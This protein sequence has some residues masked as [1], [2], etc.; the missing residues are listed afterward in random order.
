MIGFFG[1]ISF[2][3]NIL[4]FIGGFLLSL[5]WI[6]IPWFLFALARGLWLKWRRTLFINKMD[7]ILLEV[8]P[9]KDIKKTAQAMEQFF[10]GLHATMG[11]PDLWERYIDGATQRWHSLEI[12][13]SGEGPHF[14]IRTVS[15]FRDLIE[16]HIY[17]QYPEAEINQVAD[18]VNSV[19]ADIPSEEYDLWGSELIL[20]KEDAYPI[21]TYFEFEKEASS[22]E[23]RIDPIAS[24]MEVLSKI[25]P[26][27]HVWIQTLVRPI[28]DAWQEK[29]EELRDKLVGRK[30]EKKQGEVMKEAVAWKKTSQQAAQHLLTGK[31]SEGDADENDKSE[32]PFIWGKTKGEQETVAAIERNISKL[33][34][35]TIVR[36]LY[37]ARRDS[38]KRPTVNAVDGAYRQFNTQDLNGFKTNS[39][40]KTDQLDYKIELKGPRKNYRSKRILADYRKRDFIQHS[41]YIKYLKPLLFERLPILKW[42]FVRSSPFVLNVEELATI[43]HFPV[44]TVKAPLVP[45]VEARKGEPP[46]GLPKG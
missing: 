13:S 21:R 46:I 14:Y 5:W 16:S 28:G 8:I 35:E 31:P 37:I 17:A 9:P 36:Y 45:K 1:T 22:D 24:L 25:G 11:G 41:K 40:I 43:Y 12:A 27:E 30:V 33:G 20:A 23:Q 29:G 15:R 34:F 3:I 19:P 42:F 26:G 4:L 7:W 18:Y 44:E 38:W 39:K 6:W 2:I 32:T 10:C